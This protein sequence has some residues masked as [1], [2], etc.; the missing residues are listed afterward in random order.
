MCLPD[1][2]PCFVVNVAVLLAVN[3][4]SKFSSSVAIKV[5]MSVVKEVQMSVENEVLMSVS[6]KVPMSV[7]NEVPMSVAKKVPMSVNDDFAQG[8]E[9]NAILFGNVSQSM[10]TS[11][12]QGSNKLFFQAVEIIS[13]SC[14]MNASSATL[15]YLSS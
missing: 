2:A 11:M 7:S 13:P 14:G 10:A 6:N 5:P 4:A 9:I 3:V 12:L 8:V 1:C 15:I